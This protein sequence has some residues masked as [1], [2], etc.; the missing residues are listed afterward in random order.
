MIGL[1]AV[2]A[3]RENG[4]VCDDVFC[5]VVGSGVLYC[6]EWMCCDGL[7]GGVLYCVLY[8][9]CCTTT[10]VQCPLCYVLVVFSLFLTHTHRHIHSS[11]YMHIYTYVHVHPYT[12]LSAPTHPNPP[13]TQVPM[14][15]KRTAIASS[16]VTSSSGSS[17][18]SVGRMHGPFRMT[19]TRHAFKH[20]LPPRPTLPWQ[21]VSNWGMLWG[22]GRA[23]VMRA[24]S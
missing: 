10:M 24:A 3:S 9:A 14:S 8:F 12:P 11:R 7:V 13:S 5:A 15:P 20:L 6:C 16:T 23:C 22:F 17:S 18:Q 4:R 1:A 21:N 2:S 19:S